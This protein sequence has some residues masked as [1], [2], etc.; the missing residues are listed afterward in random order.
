MEFCKVQPKEMEMS[1]LYQLGRR[2]TELAHEGMGAGELEISPS[3]FLVLRD[4]YMNGESS[5]RE[6]VERTGLAQS[7]VSTS[8]ANLR[9]RGWVETGADPGDGR[10]TLAR[11]TKQVKLEGDRRRGQSAAGALDRVLAD[12]EPSERAQLARALERLHELLVEPHTPEQVRV[13]ASEKL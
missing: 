1:E 12:A 10:K 5:I 9:A 3:E 8:V 6:T 7:R 11:V 13:L 2:L 4:L